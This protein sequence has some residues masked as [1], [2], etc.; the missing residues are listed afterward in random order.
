MPKLLEFKDGVRVAGHPLHTILIHLP[1]ALLF[2]VPPLEAAGWLGGWPECWRLAF[3]AQAAG[4]LAAV[5]AAATGLVDLTA[6]SAK[7][8]I[9]S[10]GNLH[11]LAMSGAVSLFGLS[12]YLKGGTAPVPPPGLF[13][14]LA[15]SLAASALLVW[16]GWL[17]GEMVFRHGAGSRN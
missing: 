17:G 13:A 8:G 10:L 6:Q 14:I 4:L 2:L 3:F 5:P 1:I 11:M 16:G 15:L 12:L 9:A 7:P